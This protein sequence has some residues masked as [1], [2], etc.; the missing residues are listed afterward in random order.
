M[1]RDKINAAKPGIITYGIT[2]PK[3]NNTSDKIKEITLKHLER[4]N[5]LNIDALIVYDI[6]DEK[7]RINQDRPFPF[8][9]TIDADVYVNEYLQSLK[10][11]KIVYRCVGKYS[12]TEFTN[13]LIST[14]SNGNASVFVGAASS[15]QK[16]R[17]KLSDAYRLRKEYNSEL[18][19]GGVAIPERHLKNQ[20]EHIRIIY[21]IQKGCSFFVT[22]AVYDIDASLNFLSDY[23]YYCISHEMDMVPIIFTMTPCGS[24]K[25]FE[26]MKW[27]GISIPKW[28]END[29]IYSEDILFESVDYLKDIFY[30]LLDYASKKAIPIGFN[31]ESISVRKAEID[32]SIILANEIEK[33]LKGSS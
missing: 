11:P 12:A 4:I 16:V 20:S 30:E 33:V 24:I 13:W 17:L 27:L 8:L 25:T 22:Q 18:L 1:F 2:P 32:A 15:E 10:K 28:I 26:F 5:S 14:N 23:Y 31:V 29:L 7:E 9:P 19:L 6:Q 3:K 21:K